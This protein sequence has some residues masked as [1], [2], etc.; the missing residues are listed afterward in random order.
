MLYLSASF[1]TL[2]SLMVVKV[3]SICVDPKIRTFVESKV[4]MWLGLLLARRCLCKCL[5][6]ARPVMNERLKRRRSGV[7]CGW[8]S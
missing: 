6:K 3:L 7:L 1:D 2:S 8:G 4:S 5:N